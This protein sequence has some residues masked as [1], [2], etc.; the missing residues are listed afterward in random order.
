MERSESPS[1]QFETGMH[2]VTLHF[3]P[4][5]EREF[6]AEYYVHTLPIVRLV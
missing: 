3:A 5:L 4:T 6:R 2:P 1:K